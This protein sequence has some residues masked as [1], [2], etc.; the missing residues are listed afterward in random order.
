MRKC[1]RHQISS[2]GSALVYST[3]LGGR[4]SDEGADIAVDAEGNAYIAGTTNSP[5]FPVANA[6]QPQLSPGECGALLVCIDG[7]VAKLNPAGSALVY[8][9][10]LGG[11][12]ADSGIGIAVDSTGNAHVTGRT[13]SANFRTTPGVIQPTFGGGQCGNHICYD[14]FITKFKPGWRGTLFYFHWRG[15]RRLRQRYCSG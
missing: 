4:F 5:D 6:W 8:A 3:Y 9:T 7:F 1:I 12:D 10:Y 15:R 11:T 13:S 14:A 2:S